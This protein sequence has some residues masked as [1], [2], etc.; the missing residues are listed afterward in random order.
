MYR[1]KTLLSF[2]CLIVCVITI[3]VNL[4]SQNQKPIVKWGEISIDDLKMTSYPSDTNANVVILFDR[5]DVSMNE[6]YDI[7]FNRHTRI[8]ILNS[9]GF[10]WG[11]IKLN[12]YAKEDFES[13]K[14]VEGC[15]FTLDSD[16]KIIRTALKD[17]DIFEQHVDEYYDQIKFTMPSLSS[18]SVIEYRYKKIIANATFMPEWSFQR[19]EPTIWSEYEVKIPYYF[20]YVFASQTYYPFAASTSEQINEAFRFRGTTRLITMNHS[21]WAMRNVPALRSEP[22]VTTLEDYK[23][24]IMFQLAMINW[25]G[26]LPR[27]ILESWDKVGED[28]MTNQYFGVQLKGYRAIRKEVE[29]RTAGI[30]DTLQ[31]IEK[32]YDFVRQTISWDGDYRIFTNNDLDEVLE[33]KTGSAADINLL[34]TLMLCD[35]GLSADPVILSTRDNGKIQTSYP[36]VSQFNYV[37]SRLTI[38]NEEIFLDATDRLR[39]MNLL[40]Y[41]A[42]NQ[43]GFMIRK[44]TSSWVNIIPRGKASKAKIVT[45]NLQNDGSLNGNIQFKYSDYS[46]VNQRVELSQTKPEDFVKALVKSTTMGLNVDSFSISNRDSISAPLIIT[47][48]INSNTFAQVIDS[49]IYINPMTIDQI[50]DNP[51][52]SAQRSFPVDFG[53]PISEVYV[54]NLTLNDNLNLKEYPKDFLFRLP[55]KAGSYSRNSQLSG[56]SYQMISK[57]NIDQ[58]LFESKDYSIIKNFYNQIITHENEQLIIKK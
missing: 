42:L 36:L 57:Y 50:M 20:Q 58:T 26:E 10:D 40:P 51:F 53:Y 27:K 35:A 31:I 52:K 30:T 15:T 23:S 11:T 9:A 13:I 12:Y 24:K 6:E 8:K 33:K 32:I 5:G 3:S 49:F 47:A 44:S 55:M 46:G 43:V 45:L 14:D 21:Y 37:I 29:K 7:I 38:G 1:R 34:L 41:K 28:L 48:Y 56:N 25:P 17:K 39:P 16:G 18:G 22:Y 4:L 54:L 19:S 2:V